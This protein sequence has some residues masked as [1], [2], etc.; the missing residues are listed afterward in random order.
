MTQPWQKQHL[1]CMARLLFITLATIAVSK[2]T[3]TS[4]AN[5][6]VLAQVHD[7]RVKQ[8]SSAATLNLKEGQVILNG[9]KGQYTGYVIAK[10]DLPVIW[11][12]LTD[13]DNFE[14]YMPNVV[15]S[16]LLENRGNYKVFEQVQVFQLLTFSRKA[17][18]KI[19]V[20]EDYPKQIKF[21]VVEG[22]VKSL[23]GSWQ[24]DSM[25][26]N[27]YLI[28]HQVSVEPDIQ[29]SFNRGLFFTV[30]EDSVEKTLGV[31]SQESARLSGTR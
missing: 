2:G 20:N 30:Y 11:K 14:K 25:G 12:V 7:Y 21:K 1:Q 4:F 13:Y 6:P 17:K 10:G 23:Q 3:L 29:S 18:V 19:V 22:E 5:S 15:E 31:V 28:T 27:K 16:K 8:N 9:S 26:S 24:I